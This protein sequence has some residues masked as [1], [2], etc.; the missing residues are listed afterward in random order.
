MEIEKGN[1]N[2][3]PLIYMEL[4]G[5]KCS[6]ALESKPMSDIK[7]NNMYEICNILWLMNKMKFLCAC[8]DFNINTI[9]SALHT[10]TYL[11]MIRQHSGDMVTEYFD[12][13]KA[14]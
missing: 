5:E 2:R 14:T 10:L 4:Y 3:I 6:P 12:L 1:R 13:F 9:Y 7:Y 11:Y 8:V